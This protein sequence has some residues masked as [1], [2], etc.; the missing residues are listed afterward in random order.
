MFF[1]IYFFT[2]SRRNQKEHF[3]DHG[4]FDHGFFDHGFFDHGF[5]DSVYTKMEI[6]KL[7]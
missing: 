6:L 4:F 1:D 2:Q 7:R 3:F 5:F